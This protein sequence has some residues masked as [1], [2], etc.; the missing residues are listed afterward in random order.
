MK[1]K[2]QIE[3]NWNVNGGETQYNDWV[4]RVGD[5]EWLETAAAFDC[6][7]T[8]SS[9]PHSHKQLQN[10]AS[11]NNSKTPLVQT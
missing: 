11:T 8:L 4:G 5:K 9:K 1:Q 6:G 3:I 2:K 7:I 10:P